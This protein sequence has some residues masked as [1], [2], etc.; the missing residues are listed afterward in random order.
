MAI[1]DLKNK[2][3]EFNWREADWREIGKS[4]PARGA[5]VARSPLWR[6]RAAWAVGIL[7]LVWA[8]AY[9][10]VPS[11]LKSQ[12]EKIASEKLGR[13]VTVGEVDFK[14]WSLELTLRDLA[15]ARA[16][17]A[18]SAQASPQKTPQLSIKR[19]YIDAELESLLRFAPVADAVQVD[20]PV[21]FLTHQGDGRYDI[22]DILERLKSPEDAP[23]AGDPPKFAVYNI[24]VSGGRMDFTDQS[25]GKTHELRELGLSVPFLSNLKSKREIKTSPHLAFKLNGSSFDTAAEGTP[26]A[27][28]HKTDAT[29]TLRGLDLSPYLGYWPASLP[30]KLQ[31][32]VL[33]ADAKV[34]FE[35]TPATSVRISGTVTAE[36]VRLLSAQAAPAAVQAKPASPGKRAAAAETPPPARP[37]LLAFDRL[38]VSMDDVRPLEQFVKLSAVELTAPTLSLARDRAGRLNLL[39]SS[40]APVAIKKGA[41]GQGTERAGGQNDPQGQAGAA[42]GAASSPVPAAPAKAPAATPWKVQVARV[43]VRG[44]RVNWL[45]ETL[46]SP[47]DIRLAG[48]ALNASAIAIPFAAGAPLKFDGSVGLEPPAAAPAPAK[49]AAKKT[50][51]PAVPEA[52]AAPA[53]LTFNGTATDQAAQVTANV[54]SWPLGMAAKYIGQFLLPALNG[55]LDAQLGITWQAPSGDKPQALQVTAPQVALS[56][57]QL[58]EG[59]VSL[60]SVKRVD[61]AQVDIDLTGQTFKAAKLQ[62]TQPKARVERG[63]DKRW[64]YERWMVGKTPGGAAT[65]PPPPTDAATRASAP[66]WAVAVQ[67]VQLDGGAMSFSDK[68][69]AKPVAFEVSAVKAQLTGLL[70]DD[71]PASKAQAARPMPLTASLRL[72]TGRFEP[73]KV[74]FNGNL[75][76][77]PIQAQGRLV[78]DRLPLQ[79]FEPYFAETLNIELLRADASFKGRVAYR[80]LPAGT[81][82]QV[83]GDVALEEFRAN[84]LAPSE[85]LLAWKALNLRGLHVALEPAKATRVDVKETV[86]T[87]F[88]ARVIVMPDGRINLQ[89]LVKGNAPETSA[90]AAPAADATKTIAATQGAALAGGQKGSQTSAQPISPAAPAATASGGPPAVVSFGPI[91]LIN[92]KVLFSDR[93]VKPNYSADLTELTGKLSAFSSVAPAAAAGGAPVAPNMADLELRGRAEGTASLEILGKLNPLA[94]PL[95]LDIKGKVRDLELPPLSP[96]SVKYS[97]YGINRGKLSVDVGYV[98]LPDGRLTA[99]NKVILNQLAFGEKVPGSTASLPV[100]LAV[101]LLADRNG[102]IDIDLPISGSL[103]DPQFSLGPIIVK[104]IINVIVK[105]ITAPFSLLASA[106]GG[107]GEELS[108]VGFNAGS[109]ELGPEAKAG[110][111]KVAKALAERPSLQLTVVGTS[112]VE[113]ERDGFKRARLDSLVRAEKRRLA[114]KEGGTTAAAVSIGA[115]EYPALLK[116][117]YKRADMPKPRNLVGLAKDLPVPEMEKLL[118]ADIQVNDS[119]MRELAVQ[120]GVA[121][122]DYLASRDLPPERLFLGAAK[123]IPPEA[124]WTPRAELNLAM[125]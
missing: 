30:V 120:R 87:D 74:D 67:D 81:Q 71:R 111:D 38:Q 114:V 77:A 105:A 52:P 3:R 84:K 54:A 53:L 75:G 28:T 7:L 86:L 19:I 104:V 13:Q 60:V 35:Q 115:D 89:D 32:A 72:A 51:Q 45:D 49:P 94:K 102:V 123:A 43:A 92:G 36:K 99:T 40:G 85:D 83:T 101:A 112:S 24:V 8:L 66:S 57:V 37:D 79:A 34:A 48:L 73:G 95:A 76:L 25:V 117:V 21:V 122:K 107:G 124:K 16:S 64:M 42:S 78:V 10:A 97:G 96:Y 110:L 55:Q 17:Q 82:A 118:L 61:L 93:F 26:F 106:L 113:A 33:H 14:P 90:T 100:K 18:S 46:A 5:A 58:A 12:V 44:G 39:A 108:T 88:F 125:P 68:A 9:A 69:G 65:V 6:R 98:V 50:A 27:Q 1:K 20:E 109:A 4:L 119:A 70:L 121:V 11:I 56:D 116:E 41:T 31:A 15:I 47:A 22:D 2:W 80:Q 91:S 59:K 23:P 103:N 62:L 29:L 63:S